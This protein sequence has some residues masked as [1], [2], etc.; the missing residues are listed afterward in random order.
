[1]IIILIMITDVS[2]FFCIFGQNC[3]SLVYRK[4]R[5]TYQKKSR[6]TPFFRR[7]WNFFL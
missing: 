3:D 7:G 5:I 6:I 2:Y 1:M 4:S